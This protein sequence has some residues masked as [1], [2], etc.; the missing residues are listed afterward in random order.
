MTAHHS[1]ISIL[2]TS[3]RYP[4]PMAL[5]FVVDDAPCGWHILGV[6]GSEQEAQLLYDRLNDQE[7]AL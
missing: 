3:V 2:S 5:H 4:Q 1:N 7:V 6:F